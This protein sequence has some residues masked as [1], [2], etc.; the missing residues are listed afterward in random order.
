MKNKHKCN[1]IVILGPTASGKTSLAA[2]LAKELHSEIIS[3]DSRQV[4]IGMDIGTGKDLDEY[5]VEGETIPHHLIDI[6]EPSHEFSVFEYQKRFF[7]VFN[8]L[9][10]K[11]ITPVMVGGTGLYIESVLKGYALAEVPTNEKLRKSLE[12]S[13]IQSLAER[14]R[15]LNPQ[16]HNTTDLLDRNR[17][18]RAIEIAD[19]TKNNGIKEQ[20]P[21]IHPLVLGIRWDRKILRERITRRLKE[22]LNSGMTEEVEALH[23]SGISWEKIDFFGLEY[24][25]IGQFLQ[26]KINYN[27]MFQKLNSA[28]HKFAKRQETWFRRME[29]QG[30]KIHWVEDADYDTLKSLVFNELSA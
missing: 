26:G 9:S 2:R 14:L 29:K 6:V 22:R 12:K 21:E 30:I 11:G 24:R 13:S 3:A 10:E 19:F 18:V 20:R 16:L 23:A 4:Y 1:L 15:D 17:L 7:E 5:I 25:Y 28:I 8:E 27:D